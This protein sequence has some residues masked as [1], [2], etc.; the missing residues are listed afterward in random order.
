MRFPVSTVTAIVRYYQHSKV[1]SIKEALNPGPHLQ[2]MC[3]QLEPADRRGANPSVATAVDPSPGL[4][5]GSAVPHHPPQAHVCSTAVDAG[6]PLSTC[7]F[8]ALESGMSSA[9]ADPPGW[10]LV[11]DGVDVGEP[12]GMAANGPHQL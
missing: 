5:H 12:V 11:L 1:S 10:A 6:R 9:D 7:H 3:Q 8:A 2:R 4:P